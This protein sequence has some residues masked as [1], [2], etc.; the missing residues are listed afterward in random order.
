MNH[1]RPQDWKSLAETEKCLRA[2]NEALRGLLSFRRR[3]PFGGSGYGL[4]LRPFSLIMSAAM[5][6]RWISLVPS[7]MRLARTSRYMR[8]IG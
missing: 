3:I 7:K 4:I 6:K 2:L 5:T 8:S 1:P